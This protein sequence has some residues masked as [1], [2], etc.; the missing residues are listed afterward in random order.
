MA[1][2]WLRY[3]MKQSQHA[4]VIA[5]IKKGILIVLWMI[6]AFLTSRRDRHM[7]AR[8]RNDR[9]EEFSRRVMT[10]QGKGGDSKGEK[11]CLEVTEKGKMTLT[12]LLRF[13]SSTNSNQK[14][15]ILP[16]PP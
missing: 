7:I 9:G 11:T 4:A 15:G 16:E 1:E 13:K 10:Q 2:Y 12:R 6:T 3:K 5:G 14:R 8:M